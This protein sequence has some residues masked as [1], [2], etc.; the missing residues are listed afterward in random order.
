[1][2]GKERYQVS[3]YANNLPSTRWW[4][5]P[6]PLVRVKIISGSQKGTE[7]GETEYIRNAPSPDWTKIFFVEFSTDDIMELEV[8]IWDHIDGREPNWIGEAR[9]EV[10]SV[11]QERGNTKT[12]QI[13]ISEGSVYVVCHVSI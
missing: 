5:K 7:L 3:F 8:T 10:Y 4:R 12:E 1:M 11:F 6:S 9:F 2:N 13:G